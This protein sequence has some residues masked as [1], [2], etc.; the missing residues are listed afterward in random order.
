VTFGWCHGPAGTSLLF[1]ALKCA[2]VDEVAGDSV[3]AWRQRCLTSVRN[4]GIPQRMYPGFWDNDG[5]CCGTAGVADVMLDAG[6]IEFGLSLCDA[7]VDSAITDE[8][9]TYWRFL[10][11]RND[12]P[13]LPPG[14]G[15][16]QGAVGI[17]SVL[18][19]AARIA[20]GD[21]TSASRL[22]NFWRLQPVGSM[23]P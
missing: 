4:S 18:F 13:L 10:E 8:T 2:G 15:W 12:D 5:R 6:E 14:T 9:G 23:D 17:S 16:M 1:P 21:P 20:A 22:D 7:L 11:H 19:R 3:H